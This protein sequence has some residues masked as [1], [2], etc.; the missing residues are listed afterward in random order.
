VSVTVN[1]SSEKPA[2]EVTS[3]EIPQ[4]AEDPIR[5]ERRRRADEKRA[6]GR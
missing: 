1:Q 3:K 6:K 5:A 4:D 2:V